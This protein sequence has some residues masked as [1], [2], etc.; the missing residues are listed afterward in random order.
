[1][2]SE[3]TQTARRPLIGI[4]ASEVREAETIRRVKEDE[5]PSRE[6]VLGTHYTESILS[7]GGM[8]VVIPPLEP[9]LLEEL[10]DDRIDG[11]CISGG[12]DVDPSFYECD[13]D[14]NLGPTDPAFDRFE[15]ELVRQGVEREI[16]TL[17][18]CRGIQ[19]LNVS[20]GGTLIQHLPDCSS[21]SHRQDEPGYLP[22]HPIEILPDSRLAELAGQPTLEVNTYHHQ[23]IHDLGHDLRVA[24]RAPDGVIEAVEGVNG[25][26]LLGLQWHAE[27]MV[28]RRLETEIFRNLIDAAGAFALDRTGNLRR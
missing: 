3:L 21:L 10:L 1:M 22:G 9:A 20:L 12:P 23:A 24:A 19:V 13:P 28:P 17:A 16:P 15:L 25:G 5:P 18:I 27:L 2:G 4:S 6:I 7:A 26:F 11:L 14:P 8:P